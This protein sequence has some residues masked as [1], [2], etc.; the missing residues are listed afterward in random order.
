[1]T[2]KTRRP[3]YS[4]SKLQVYQTC[5]RQYHFQYVQ[6][7]PRRAWANQSFGSSLHRTLA[8]LHEQGGPQAQTL[9]DTQQLLELTWSSA[10]YDSRAHSQAELERG[11]KLLQAYFQEWSQE[12]GTSIVLEKRFSAPFRDTMFLGIIDRVDRR[13]DGSLEIIDYK[14]GFAPE[15][16]P[17]Q[18]VQQLSLY[19]H[20]IQHKL[21][22]TPQHHSVHYLASNVRLALPLD[23]DFIDEV[24]DF[25]YRTVQRLEGDEQFKP[26]KAAHCEW[27]DYQHLCPVGRGQQEP[28]TSDWLED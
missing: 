12:D 20:L 6:K 21:G 18:T 8:A 14:S 26:I 16:L 24:L 19:H 15:Q 17:P 13:S 28:S 10:G 11:K 5:P 2:S 27:C 23:A 25:A 3:Q 7:L 9:S 22:E 1:M 4:P